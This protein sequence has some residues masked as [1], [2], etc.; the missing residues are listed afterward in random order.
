MLITNEQIKIIKL[1][2][3]QIF[4]NYWKIL[5]SSDNEQFQV[6]GQ[7]INIMKDII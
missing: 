7:L 5:F 3:F 2:A 1:L 4:Y 6:M